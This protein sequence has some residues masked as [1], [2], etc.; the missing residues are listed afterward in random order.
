MSTL[1][2]TVFPVCIALILGVVFTMPITAGG[3]PLKDKPCGMC[4]KDPKAI[5]PKTHP[6]LG[7]DASKSCLSCHKPDPARA[8]AN[9]FST[10]IH[11]IHQGGKTTQECS[12]CHAL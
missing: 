5:L 6:D 1:K 3:P 8:E 11:K 2:R 12:A 9:K 10:T 4:H 7:A